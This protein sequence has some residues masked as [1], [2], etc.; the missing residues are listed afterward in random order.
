MIG[1]HVGSAAF[2][3]LA[4]LA[5]SGPTTAQD[6]ANYPTRPIHI[7]VPFAPGGAS[8]FAIRLIQP[9]ME[10]ALGQTLVIDNRT[11]A[12][13]NVGMELA[14]RA[15]PDGYTLF[16]G[17]IGTIAINPHFFPELKVTP[18]RDFIPVS[19]AAETPGIVVASEKFPP[20]SLKEMIAYAKANPGKINYAAAG[21]STLNTLAMEQFRH[22]LGLKM[23][24]VPYKGGAGPAVV[25]LLAGN[26][27]V[28][29]VTLSSVAQ[30]VKAG[31]LKG[32]AV[33]TKERVE[34]LPDVPS[35][36]ELGF[37]EDVS[38]SWQGLFAVKDT[39]APIVAKLHAAV[40]KAMADPDVRQHMI[41]ASMV[42]TSSPTP[43]SFKA[44]VATESTKWK[45]V[46]EQIKAADKASH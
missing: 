15:A 35:V 42:P 37:P 38:G 16:L 32:F 28:M 40:L 7:I 6:S 33:T 4:L 27:D 24:Q 8:D 3:L 23:T 29:F 17:N 39:P 31:K 14:A 43:E 36:V 34:S 5:A 9:A 13:G 1:Q 21:V 46:V 10:K 18:E 26:V 22:R 20:N 44:F 11:G 19:L 41:A 45:T 25:D 12:A 2:A 30:F